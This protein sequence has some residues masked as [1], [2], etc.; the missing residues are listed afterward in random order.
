MDN[1][2][3]LARELAAKIQSMPNVS[4]VYIPQA[5]TTPAWR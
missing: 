1:A 5:S 4:G 3:K 2:Y